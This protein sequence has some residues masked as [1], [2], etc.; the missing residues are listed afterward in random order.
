M[1]H[2]GMQLNE[3]IVYGVK[4][5]QRNIA[6]ILLLLKEYCFSPLI[7][8]TGLQKYFCNLWI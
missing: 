2:G 3:I 7:N 4:A 5:W 1:G 8:Q 6:T